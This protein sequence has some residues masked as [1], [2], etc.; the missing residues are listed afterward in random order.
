MGK[1]LALTLLVLGRKTGITR[2]VVM[3]RV[4]GMREKDR[5]LCTNRK[6]GL[7]D[8]K[9]LPSIISHCKSLSNE[10]LPPRPSPLLTRLKSCPL[11]SANTVVTVARWDRAGPK[12]LRVCQ[13]PVDFAPRCKSWFHFELAEA[14]E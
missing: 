6:Q 4:T 10:S 9:S 11:R 8:W 2:L 7:K 5:G 14:V 3:E 12:G 13:G 1:V